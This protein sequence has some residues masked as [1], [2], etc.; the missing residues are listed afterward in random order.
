MWIQGELFEDVAKLPW[1]GR[2]PRSLTRGHE[3]LFLRRE[4]QK[5]DR[6]FV[7]Q[8]QYDSFLAAITGRYRYGG[9][10]LLQEPPGGNDG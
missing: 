9:A 10:P 6:F 8:D 5:D 3:A 2:T 1:Y 7:D 4:P